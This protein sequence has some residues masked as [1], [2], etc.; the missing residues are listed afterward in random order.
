MRKAIHRA[1]TEGPTEDDPLA[2]L[3][4]L[5]APTADIERMLAEIWAGRA[6]RSASEAEH[7]EAPVLSKMVIERERRR[8]S[9]RVEDGE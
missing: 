3:G 1:L 6:C 4:T 5:G 8:P 7:V 9:P 2:G